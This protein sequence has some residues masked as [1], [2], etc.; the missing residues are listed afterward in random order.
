M[1]KLIHFIA[2]LL[3]A[4]GCSK[5]KKIEF[6]EGVSLS[7][8]GINCGSKFETGELTAVIHSQDV[9][10]T[11]KIGLKIL[12]KGADTVELVESLQV[13]VKPDQDR[14]SATLTFDTGGVF[15]VQAFKGEDK[16][17]E[18]MIEIV[19]IE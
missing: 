1:K 17:S 18:S 9:F 2:A 11:E 6:C 3:I 15:T 12:E 7:G 8:K 16:I 5:I 4:T 10:G 14:A 13:S 19:E